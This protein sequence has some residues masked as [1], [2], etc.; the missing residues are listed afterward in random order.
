MM[1]IL[2]LPHVIAL[3]GLS[4]ST[5]YLYMQKQQFPNQVKLGPRAIGWVEDEVVEWMRARIEIRNADTKI[6]SLFY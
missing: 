2:R 3:T 1:K 4:R 6:K 5:L